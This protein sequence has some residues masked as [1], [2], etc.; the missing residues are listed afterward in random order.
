MELITLQG[1]RIGG[2]QHFD[3]TP[4]MQERVFDTIDQ[5]GTELGHWVSLD[6][7]FEDLRRFG[8]TW[9]FVF[10]MLSSLKYFGML[11]QHSFFRLWCY[12]RPSDDHLPWTTERHLPYVLAA[13]KLFGDEWT[14]VTP[15][16][17]AQHFSTSGGKQMLTET[18]NM[19]VIERA[20]QR[21]LKK[22]NVFTRYYRRGPDTM[23]VYPSRIPVNGRIVHIPD[24]LKRH[25]S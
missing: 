16:Q 13:W 7:A 9:S 4:E 22:N 23:I 10:S 5:K 17:V 21:D 11:E 12:R 14:Q 3:F 20:D 24:E 1:R 15:V 19:G 6:T 2:R 18:C 8:Y 25:A